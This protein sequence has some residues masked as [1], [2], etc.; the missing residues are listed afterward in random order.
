MRAGNRWKNHDLLQERCR[1]TRLVKVGHDE[2]SQAHD[3]N[4]KKPLREPIH[5]NP[6]H[7]NHGITWLHRKYDEIDDEKRH[8]QNVKFDGRSFNIKLGGLE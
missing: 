3:K 6:P 2:H 5:P 4:L 7:C 8:Q 1:A